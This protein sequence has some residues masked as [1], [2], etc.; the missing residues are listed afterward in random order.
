M[1]VLLL[2]LL[3]MLLLL[4]FFLGGSVLLT[5]TIVDNEAVKIFSCVIAFA[6]FSCF[7]FL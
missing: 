5:A 1:F 4:F 3:L 6:N 7:F 2:L